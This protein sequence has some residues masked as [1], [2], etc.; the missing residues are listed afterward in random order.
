M[1]VA[2]SR[3]VVLTS[4]VPHAFL[5]AVVIFHQRYIHPALTSVPGVFTVQRSAV[6]D[7]GAMFELI[8]YKMK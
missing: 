2:D 6:A 3:T 8:T 5:A 4:R 1:L 7:L